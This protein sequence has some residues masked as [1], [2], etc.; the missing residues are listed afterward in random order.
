[1]LGEKYVT[2]IFRAYKINVRVSNFYVDVTHTS[3]EICDYKI[4]HVYKIDV[5]DCNFYVDVTNASWEIRDSKMLRVYKIA[6]RDCNFYLNVTEAKWEIRKFKLFAYFEAADLRQVTFMSV[7]LQFFSD[8]WSKCF[9]EK[10]FFNNI[11]R[12]VIGEARR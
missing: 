1:M 2:K 12:R 10:S 6:V 4:V 11:S 7:R 5:R 3:W 9:T 8:N